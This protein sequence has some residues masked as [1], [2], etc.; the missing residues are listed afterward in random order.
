MR[1]NEIAAQVS[2]TEASIR[3]VLRKLEEKGIV[4]RIYIGK[5]VHY[6]MN[7]Y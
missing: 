3:N 5:Y 1:P 6:V 7:T 4:K 2:S